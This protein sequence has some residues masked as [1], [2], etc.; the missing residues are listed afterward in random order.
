MY[1]SWLHALQTALLLVLGA[2]VCRLVALS[3]H[4][5]LSKLLHPSALFA[6]QLMLIRWA[7]HQV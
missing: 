4:A 6:E 3:A 7:L 1:L 2:A 5:T